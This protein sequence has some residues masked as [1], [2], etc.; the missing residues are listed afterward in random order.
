MRIKAAIFDVD[1]T[2]LDS[3]GLWK[4]IGSDY[5]RA[6]GISPCE[7]LDEILKPMSTRQAAHYYQEAY[8]L[9]LSTDEIVDEVN[10][11]IER[12]Y[13]DEVQLKAGASEFL[14]L[15]HQKE[16][17]MC[18]VTASECALVQAALRRLNALH[19]FSRIFTCESVG[20]GKDEPVIYETALSSL[21]AHKSETL[22]FEDALYAIRTA[23]AA[24][25]RV[26]AVYDAYESHPEAVQALADF[27][28]RDFSRAITLVNE[29]GAEL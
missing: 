15:L 27:Y 1:G 25:F 26:A 5:L 2:L 9:S 16:V 23:K 22:V 4:N 10:A 29:R 14:A 21:G 18:I 8:G 20:H 7:G 24:G 28:V 11:M 13:R 3:M 12:Y 17:S 19:F 6:R